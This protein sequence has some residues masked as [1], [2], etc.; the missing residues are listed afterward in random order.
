MNSNPIATM[1]SGV[2]TRSISPV[3]MQKSNAAA[4]QPSSVRMSWRSR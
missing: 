3:G 1:S 2:D 4:P